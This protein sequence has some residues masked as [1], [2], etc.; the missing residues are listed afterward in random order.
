MSKPIRHGDAWR[1]RWF[2]E[3]GIRK[4]AVLSTFKDAEYVLKKKLIQT[5][6][7]KAGILRPTPKSIPF[8]EFCEYYQKYFSS[9]KRQ[10]KDD[11]SIINAHL[12]PFFRK[13]PLTDIEYNVERF[14]LEKRHLSRKTVHNILTLLISMLRV[15]HDRKW[16]AAIPKIKKPKVRLL[17]KDFRYLKTEDEIC[18]FLIAARRVDEMAFVLYAT[19]IFTGLRAGELAGLTW[20]DISFEKRLITVQRSYQGL[21]KNGETRHVPLLDVLLPILREWRLKS[22]VSA[23]FPS[24]KDTP[25][26]ESARVFQELL[27]RT[28]EQGH[29]PKVTRNGKQSRYIVFHDL[30]HSFASLWMLKGGDMFK[31]QKILGHKSIQMTQRYSHLAPEAYKEDF[32][33]FNS[34]SPPTLPHRL[35]LSRVDDSIA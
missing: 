4:S 12:L 5:E 27:H 24:R 9:Q 15:A 22:H 7:I 35:T 21:T 33:R 8:G 19:A 1:I 11:E 28:L 32:G 31:L 34:T 14:K 23:V 16:L 29:F 17:E 10:P 25:L 2:D 3:N 18:R 26:Q 6:E 20:D 30:R 13:I